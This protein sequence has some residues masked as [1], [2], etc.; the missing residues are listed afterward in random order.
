MSIYQFMPEGPIKAECLKIARKLVED[1][2]ERCGVIADRVE[3]DDIIEAAERLLNN[4]DA[5]E[6]IIN[7]A[8]DRFY[9]RRP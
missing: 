7:E 2:L 6:S 8:L 5:E 1:E 3:D 4:S 9:P